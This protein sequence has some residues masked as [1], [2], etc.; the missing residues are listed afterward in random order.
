[1][2]NQLIVLPCI[3]GALLS[4][5]LALEATADPIQDRK[6]ICENE[7]VQTVWEKGKELE[8]ADQLAHGFLAALCSP[9]N[10]V[11]FHGL[12]LWSSAANTN[13]ELWKRV[14]TDRKRKTIRVLE[15]FAI[16]AT[17][18]P[19]LRVAAIETMGDVARY[20]GRLVGSPTLLITLI[21]DPKSDRAI[22][23][24]ALRSL[25][26]IAPEEAI[27]RVESITDDYLRDFLHGVASSS[28]IVSEE[29]IH[30]IFRRVRYPRSR[31]SRRRDGTIG[32]LTEIV[33]RNSPPVKARL[34]LDFIAID[35]RRATF[36]RFGF[37]ASSIRQI[38][39][40]GLRRATSADQFEGL[41]EVFQ[42][43]DDK[44]GEIASAIAGAIERLKP[45]DALSTSSVLDKLRKWP[46]A[47]VKALTDELARS[48]NAEPDDTDAK[49]ESSP[50][51]IIAKFKTSSSAQRF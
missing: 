44:D 25:A 27:S 22:A 12:L 17:A 18:Q 21:D 20:T 10:A 33:S 15:S 23:S 42:P 30:K 47:R 49:R 43:S 3:L 9:R 36:N 24:A 34:A 39:V 35:S 1:M 29:D 4:S 31:A 38:A 46:D 5:A 16:D 48:A 6:Q 51:A 26:W 28:V 7:R 2:T 11:A 13:T 37:D 32:H 45:D 14:V 41:L 8:P 50:A 19:T 40:A